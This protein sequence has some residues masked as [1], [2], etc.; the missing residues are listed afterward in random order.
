MGW[1]MTRVRARSLLL[2]GVPLMAAASLAA[3][4]DATV[5]SSNIVDRADFAPVT[6]QTFFI[7]IRSD[8]IQ[9]DGDGVVTSSPAGINCTITDR[10]RS[11]TCDASFPDGTTVTLTA[12]PAAGNTFRN[13]VGRPSYTT[14]T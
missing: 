7:G 1:M 5:T 6:V 11:G 2:A 10:S 13:W 3:G 14:T 12:T 8:V 9:N 4:Q